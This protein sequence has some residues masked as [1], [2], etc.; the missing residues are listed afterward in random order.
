LEQTANSGFAA[1]ISIPPT[2]DAKGRDE[3]FEEMVKQYHWLSI[4]HINL[5]RQAAAHQDRIN[6]L[7]GIVL[8]H[9]EVIEKLQK[10]RDEKRGMGKMAEGDW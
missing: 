2:A 5:Q 9:E 3:L 8:R 6:E 10:K 7:Y 1:K 4:K